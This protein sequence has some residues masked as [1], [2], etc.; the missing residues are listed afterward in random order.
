MFFKASCLPFPPS[1]LL[2]VVLMREKRGGGVRTQQEGRQMRPL[3]TSHLLSISLTFHVL[4]YPSL[5]ISVTFRCRLCSS[6]VWL[7]R[8]GVK[9]IGGERCGEIANKG[10]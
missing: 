6:E 5:Y 8:M 2:H 4:F 10:H 7:Y 9:D 3:A 1:A